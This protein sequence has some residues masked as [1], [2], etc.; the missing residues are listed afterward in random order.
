MKLVNLNGKTAINPNPKM[1]IQVRM[2]IHMCLDGNLY[3][4]KRPF[5]TFDLTVDALEDIKDELIN[6][7]GSGFSAG[8]DGTDGMFDKNIDP[9]RDGYPI[10]K[11]WDKYTDYSKYDQVA[12][13]L[14]SNVKV[15]KMLR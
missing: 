7:Y 8:S 11:S 4:S 9:D 2:H 5:E 13:Q 6:R 14:C 12:F 10:L 1:F 3:Q 15:L